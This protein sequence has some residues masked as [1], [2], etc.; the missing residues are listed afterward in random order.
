MS[1]VLALVLASLAP[2]A[3]QGLDFNSEPTELGP[4]APRVSEWI[5]DLAWVDLA[6]K[7]SKLSAVAGERGLV[8][9][10]RDVDCPLSKRYAPR[11]AEMEPELEKLGFGLLY[12]G[13]QPRE[14]CQ[15]DVETYALKKSYAV[16]P[17]GSIASALSASTTTEVFVLDRARTLRYRGCI[18]DQYGLGFAKPAV[19]R[20]FLREALVAVAAGRQV[21]SPATTA[22]GCLLEAGASAPPEVPLTWNERASRIVQRRCE[23][24]HRAGGV[25]PFPLETYEQ[26]QRRARMM[27]FVLEEGQMPPWFAEHDSGPWR[28]DTSLAAQEKDDLVAWIAAGTP[29]GDSTHAPLPIARVTGWSIGEPDLVASMGQTFDV[30]AEGVVDYQYFDVLLDTAEDRW[31]QAVEIRP[32][33]RS[34]V[35]HVILWVDEPGA[36]KRRD[37]AATFFTAHAPGTQPLRF[38]HGFAKRVPAGARLTFQMHYTPNGTTATDRTEVGFVFADGPPKAEIVTAS[39]LNDNF[40]IPPGAF[41]HEVHAEYVFPADAAILTLFPHSHLRGVRWLYELAYPDGTTG[42]LLSVPQYNFNWQLFYDL[43]TPLEVPRGTKLLA[44]AW[45]DNS[46]GNP[47]NPDPTATVHFGEQTFDEMMI[48]YVNWV[49]A[50][51]RTPIEASAPTSAGGS[52]GR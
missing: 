39:A 47:A 30:P 35:H 20:E 52:R 11:L 21:E 33:A 13:V 32:G 12:V 31:V 18:D 48:G 23:G 45:Y 46:D 41:D 16:D 6:G 22:Q 49:P 8:I 50:G 29:E 34:V 25:A 3:P 19:E 9:A 37:G 17:E 28:N 26:V 42:P 14:D 4:Q 1:I 38:P 36:Q 15:R 24:C 7:E 43:E 10:L 44:T 5:P 2:A 40:A 27:K 51:A